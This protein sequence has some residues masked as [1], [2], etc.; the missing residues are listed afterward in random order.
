VT[1]TET[2]DSDGDSGAET[3]PA[4][5]AVVVVL[6]G[7]IV[8]G[9]TAYLLDAAGQSTAA[10]ATWVLGYGVTV[11]VTWYLWLRPLDLVGPVESARSGESDGD[12][13]VD[14]SDDPSA[15]EA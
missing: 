5:L 12:E 9:V 11:F 8:P 13:R 14:E 10:T 2:S 4:P 3:P 6:A 15:A 1:G 7:L